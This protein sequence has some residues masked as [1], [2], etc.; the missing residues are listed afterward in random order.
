MKRTIVI[1]ICVLFLASGL[2]RIGVGGIM[3]GQS[4]GWWALGGEAEEALIETERF[5]GERESNLIGF[6]PVSYFGI[7]IFM[8]LSI[9]L[10]AIGQIG[11]RHWGMVL[12]VL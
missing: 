5:I 9:S 11:R 6:T 12:I 2:I 7:I 10:G 1:V 3:I 4:T 8:G